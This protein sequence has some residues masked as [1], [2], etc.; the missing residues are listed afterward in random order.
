M[1][2]AAKVQLSD[3][4]ELI[5]KQESVD[6][7][8]K[9]TLKK[10]FEGFAREHE[11][12]PLGKPARAKIE[13]QSA[14]AVANKEIEKWKEVV[15][16]NRNVETLDLTQPAPPS[17]TL[18]SIV[19]SEERS[20]L[21]KAIDQALGIS[22][23]PEKEEEVVAGRAQHRSKL[24]YAYLKQKR[25][26][27]IKSKL[28]HKIKNKH[29]KA[30]AP[31]ATAE[32]EDLMRAEERISLRHSR[33]QFKKNVNR[34]ASRE[35]TFRDDALAKNEAVRQRILHVSKVTGE[36]IVHES[37]SEDDEA[38]LAEQL[39][40]EIED[41]GPQTGVLGMKFMKEARR[42]QME[43]EMQTSKELLGEL[44][45]QDLGQ[46][47]GS[48]FK[49]EEDEELPVKRSKKGKEAEKPSKK[50][51]DT[52]K[53]LK[54]VSLKA[55][56]S[57]FDPKTPDEQ[58]LIDRAFATDEM[59]QVAQ[60][61]WEGE[62]EEIKPL[63]RPGWGN[64]AGLD[65]KEPVAHKP[66]VYQ[67]DKVLMNEDR[68]TKATKYLVKKLPYPYKSARQFEAVHNIPLGKDWNSLSVHRNLI[69]PE[70]VTTAGT[71]IEP[72]SLDETQ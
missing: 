71:I 8:S 35:S 50:A 10:K 70:V 1:A 61:E 17:A 66:K 42:K 31:E 23:E 14:Y 68:N 44:Q 34:F 20:K 40:L 67:A 30:N 3:L 26:A 47:E 54:K 16:Q 56:K 33:S 19:V 43:R 13:R 45:D 7:L 52:E 2:Q 27:K 28:Y 64:W 41:E 11:I 37:S 32:Q 72:I 9:S 22:A 69:A 36:G 4:I 58:A 21:Q 12:T 6:T 38:Y 63:R 24:F 62:R 15:Q 46:G 29:K 25:I 59:D 5:N 53:P 65:I 57:I 18:E 51:K 49:F 60:E 48:K 55:P 39:K